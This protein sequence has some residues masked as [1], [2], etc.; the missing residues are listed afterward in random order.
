MSDPDDMNVMSPQVSNFMNRAPV[1]REILRLINL[2]LTLNRCEEG[3]FQLLNDMI[4]GKVNTLTDL[5]RAT[6]D[7]PALI[8]LDCDQNYNNNNNDNYSNRGIS[9]TQINYNTDASYST[10]SSKS[11]KTSKTRKS[12]KSTKSR[13]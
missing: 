2:Q 6:P 4:M 3:D 12:R 5:Y 11:T 1:R 7:A 10:R 8:E 9:P 13:S